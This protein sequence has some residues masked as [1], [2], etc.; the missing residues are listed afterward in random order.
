MLRLSLYFLSLSILSA[1]L[2]QL[3]VDLIS[4]EHW[5]LSYSGF[6]KGQ[7]PDR[8][9]GAKNPS[10]AQ[11]IEDLNILLNEGFKL[12]RMYDC[13]TNTQMTLEV[14]KKNKYATEKEIEKINQEVKEIV[15]DAVKFAEESQF[16]TEQD[17][18]DS[19]YEQE[20][21]PFIKD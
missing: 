7:H 16:P 19:V 10:E 3:P 12:V 4:D 11:I 13:D 20:D 15:A 6:R 9:D 2:P 17:L 1:S 18:Y 5:A 8:G 14:I 21:Y